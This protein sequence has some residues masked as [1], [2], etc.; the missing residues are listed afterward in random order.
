MNRKNSINKI[1]RIDGLNVKLRTPGTNAELQI[2]K[3]TYIKDDILSVDDA[4][5]FEELRK[6]RKVIQYSQDLLSFLK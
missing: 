4:I 2:K 3:N 1:V 5:I 6:S